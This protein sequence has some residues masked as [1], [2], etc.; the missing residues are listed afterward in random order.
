MNLQNAILDGF[1][2]LKDGSARISLTTR[3]LS[4]KQL[5]ELIVNFNKEILKIDIPDE[6]GESKSAS[7]RLRDVLYL[8][9]RNHYKTQF[10]TFAVYYAH[11]MEQ[12]IDG[13][14]NKID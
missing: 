12:L 2:I 11:I 14:K 9:W 6:R 4:P 3:E 13:Y 10:K 1:R 8:V 5:A 7:Q